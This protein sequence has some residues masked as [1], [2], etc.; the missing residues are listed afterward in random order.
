MEGYFWLNEQWQK[1]FRI[2]AKKLLGTRG[3][4]TGIFIY[5]FFFI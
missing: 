1:D 5:L 3:M 4:L 2:N